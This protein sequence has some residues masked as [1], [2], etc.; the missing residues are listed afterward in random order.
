MKKIY[1]KLVR[2]KIPQIISNNNQVC[3]TKILS[4]EL[5]LKMLDQKLKEECN[6]YIESN[7]IEELADL[8]EVILAILNARGISYNELEKIRHSKLERS[9]GFTKKIFLES[10]TDN[11]T[12]ADNS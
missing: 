3:S 10:V 1:N 7:D 5:Y 8:T 6:E 2:D 12:N 4:D 9:G 11:E